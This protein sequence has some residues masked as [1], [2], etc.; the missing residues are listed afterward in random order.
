M[1]EE[2]SRLPVCVFWV[3][4]ST[5]GLCSLTRTKVLLVKGSGSVGGGGGAGGGG[6]IKTLLMM[7]KSVTDSLITLYF[8]R[9]IQV[10]IFT[11]SPK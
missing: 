11:H 3:F 1:S 8:C 6:M 9:S 5:H 7:V 10:E 4:V 2:V